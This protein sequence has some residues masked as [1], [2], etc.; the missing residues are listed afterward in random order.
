[1]TSGGRVEPA[2]LSLERIIVINQRAVQVTGERHAIIERTRLEG[3]YNRPQNRWHYGEDD[4]VVLA[5]Q[6]L[7]GVA[8][9]HGFEQGNK[10]TGFT[11]SVIFLAMNGYNIVAED[12]SYCGKLVKRV[13]AKSL[14]QEKFI[15][16]VR[17][18]IEAVV[19]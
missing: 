10:R 8:N 4:I 13:V 3:G 11:A 7:F 2:W 9:A 19:S 5:V 18:L 12:T 14:T 6:L 15:E 17:P 1:V 16:I